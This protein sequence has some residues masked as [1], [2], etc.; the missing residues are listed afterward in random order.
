MR[1]GD[2]RG[3]ECRDAAVWPGD[4]RDLSVADGEGGL[5]GRGRVVKFDE[6]RGYGF[7]APDDGGEDIFVHARDL[8]SDK[9]AFL[10]GVSVEFE[11]MDGE[12]GLKGYDVQIVAPERAA[13]PARAG[14]PERGEQVPLD[15]TCEVLSTAEFRKELT[16]SFIQAVPDLTAAQIVR[17]RDRV[18][19]LATAYGWIED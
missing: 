10:P 4:L 2:D 7:V 3:S 17:I 5:V 12:R 1:A 11:V 15:G 6:V 8:L 18:I 14:S 13:V 16:E 9:N 19:A